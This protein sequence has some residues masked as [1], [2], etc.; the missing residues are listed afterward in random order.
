MPILALPEGIE[1]FV[2]YCDASRKG[3]GGVLIQKEKV[4]DDAGLVNSQR[5]LQ[6]PRQST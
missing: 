5:V 6:A 2:V 1:N 3:L 4:I